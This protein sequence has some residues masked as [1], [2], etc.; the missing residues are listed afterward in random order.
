MRIA[1]FTLFLHK[2]FT[3][4][5]SKRF[6]ISQPRAISLL[7]IACSLVYVPFLLIPGMYFDDWAWFWV[8]KVEGQG[9]LF[10]YMLQS[11]HPGYWPPLAL[12]YEVGGEYAGILA[13]IIAVA[14]H[15]ASA[16]L[17][18][19]ILRRPRLT[20]GISVWASA[21][22]ILSP[23][24]Y[25]RGT[26]VHGVYDIFMLFYLLSI[27]LLSSE[28]KRASFLAVG[29][30]IISLSLETLMFLEP[31][32][33]LFVHQ[34]RKGVRNTIRKCMPF[35]AISAAF[36]L[37][38]LIW[39]KPYGPYTDT[40][41]ISFSISPLW[42]YLVANG[43]YYLD[44]ISYTLNSALKLA[45]WPGII[46][47]G[48]LGFFLVW[49]ASAANNPKS[50]SRWEEFV[51]TP[52]RLLFGVLLS[53]LGAF[54]YMLIGR[55]PY[56]W[57]FHSRLAY[58]SIPGISILV[59]TL[60]MA[61]P[62]RLIRTKV[63]LAS[64]IILALSS[65]QITKWYI[66]DSLVQRD[67]IKQLVRIIP[68]DLVHPPMF[69]LRTTPKLKW[70]MVLNR[71]MRPYDLNVPVNLL[72]NSIESPVFIYPDSMAGLFNSRICTITSNDLYPCPDSTA[73]LEYDL[74]TD[75]SSVDRMSYWKLLKSLFVNSGKSPPMAP[76]S[77]QDG[78]LDRPKL[79]K[80]VSDTPRIIGNKPRFLPF[81]I[82][83]VYKYQMNKELIE[84]VF[85]EKRKFAI[86]DVLLYIRWQEGSWSLPKHPFQN[87]ER[88]E[89]LFQNS[90]YGI[91]KLK[92]HK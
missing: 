65:L 19:Q 27:W 62:H 84:E 89:I 41:K 91:L 26:L 66:Y 92:T 61:I 25:A 12:F 8:S 63:F 9:R 75:N 57:D 34:S 37:A 77:S 69:H 14:C 24:Y 28:K 47:L 2:R 31:L 22:Y 46:A 23:F 59:A 36:I 50:A 7:F 90:E 55:V 56:W 60:V 38:K 79:E 32:R 81:N 78:W 82:N 35:W 87:D 68:T 73:R 4:L 6:T 48:V 42:K 21:I 16:V 33:V 11:G 86:P 52:Q 49:R 83:S 40:N 80:I 1:R 54:P 18:Y 70:V 67:L 72:R 88:F 17:L 43:R 45:F 29:A 13:R 10:E 74:D 64:L 20:R 3:L 71:T 58:V 51:L 76:I 53:I 39:L 5:N 15:L 30:F 44:G 85:F